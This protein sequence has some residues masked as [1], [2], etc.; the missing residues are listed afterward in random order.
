MSAHL[1]QRAVEVSN[2]RD[3]T[4]G[5][6]TII[7]PGLVLTAAHVACRQGPDGQPV[8]VRA[9]DG[10][11]AVN[12]QVTWHDQGLDSAI[13]QTDRQQLGVDVP[14]VRWG[15]LTCE[16]PAE[17]P[18]CT[19]IG[20]PRA[21][22][23]RFLRRSP[24]VV[25]SDP[26]VVNGY[27]YPTTAARSQR[28]ALE[29]SDARPSEPTLWQGMSGAGIFCEGLLVGLATQAPENW[30][31]SLLLATPISWLLAAEGFA[32]SVSAATGLP[33]QLQPADLQ[34]LL[35]DTPDPRL[36]ASY[37]LSAQ[38]QVV[39]MSGFEEQSERLA[40]WCH[41]GRRIDVAA[42]TGTGGVGKTRLA[43]ELLR[44]LGEPQ[45]GID[46]P[47]P[48]AGGF[49][50]ETPLRT[51]QY[52]ALTTANRPLL[53]IVDYAETRLDQVDE[54]LNIV[55]GS[56]GTA[57]PIRI[58]LLAR[59]QGSW[60]QPF[61]RSHRGTASM[62][63]GLGV[64][65]ND[66]IDAA[67][68]GSTYEAARHAFA[69]RIRILK[70]AG[71]EDDWDSAAA[72]PATPRR[73]APPEG[74][75]SVLTL[76]MTALAD[77]LAEIN[78][79]F[80]AY[81]HPTDVLLAH[82]ERYWQRI[83]RARGLDGTF[84]RQPGLLRTM[85]ATQSLAGAGDRA[86]ARAAIAAGLEAHHHGL[87][88]GAGP[89]AHLVDAVEDMLAVLYPSGSGA[90][91]GSIGPD[92]LAG[93][94]ISEVEEASDHQFIASLL[95]HP[96]LAQE[97]RQQGLTVISRAA[98]AQPE[99]AVSAAKAVAEAPD[100]LLSLATHEVA[101]QLG[102]SSAL[103]WITEV[104]TAVEDRAQQ[105]ATDPALSKWAISMTQHALNRLRT[106]SAAAAEPVPP[107]GTPDSADVHAEAQQVL[108]L[109]QDARSRTIQHGLA[110][111]DDSSGSSEHIADMIAQLSWINGARVDAT[112]VE[113]TFG[114]KVECL[115]DKPVVIGIANACH[116]I[117][118][119]PFDDGHTR[120]L[121]E[122]VDRVV[123]LARSVRASESRPSPSP[124]AGRVGQGGSYMSLDDFLRLQGDRYRSGPENPEE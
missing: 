80:A 32:K 37:L 98:D 2:P 41:S 67:A 62:G 35:D 19:A 106:R 38:A 81:G 58:L 53:L 39:P 27:I 52:E 121:S 119:I 102:K 99:L 108:S 56:G 26:K 117:A 7:A 20:F 16:H 46:S 12:A 88:I 17:R 122:A 23:R 33:A 30:D 49:L 116:S 105:A 55:S 68:P 63:A 57:Q 36:S 3:K 96:S 74:H 48:W 59:D 100:V 75:S 9:L 61:R 21:M 85:V 72:T 51:A 29:V 4:F 111:R 86:Q 77:L 123:A 25:V 101:D 24:E 10:G 110:S 31:A 120:A 103:Q 84:Q 93:E 114:G 78:P 124:P 18:V 73:I 113:D 79:A 64:E 107:A 43:S 5:S 45:A 76:H 44:H 28:Y 92:L 14:I 8:L 15:E 1:R 11:P 60:W 34:A 89:D 112:V 90:R 6:G 42:V 87:P 70:G 22:R 115:A 40:Q 91:W 66:C 71:I 95:Q 13:L 50:S 109:L 94:V 65:V 83:A 104:K 69:E 82:E 118:G 54:L 97:Q 47:R